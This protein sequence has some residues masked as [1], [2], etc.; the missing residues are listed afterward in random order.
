MRCGDAWGCPS[1]GVDGV[2]SHLRFSLGLALLI[3]HN[4]Y[5]L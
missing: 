1:T 2:L 5:A 3:K 4:V